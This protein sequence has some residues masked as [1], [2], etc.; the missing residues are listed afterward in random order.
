[1]YQH[2]LSFGPFDGCQLLLWLC[3]LVSTLSGFICLLNGRQHRLISCLCC[4]KC[5]WLLPQCTLKLWGIHCLSDRVNHIPFSLSYVPPLLFYQVS[6]LSMEW[7]NVMFGVFSSKSFD[8]S[9]LIY[10]FEHCVPVIT[11]T[12][13]TSS[14][15]ALDHRPSAAI[16]V[17]GWYVIR[18]TK[19]CISYFL[20]QSSL[21]ISG[22]CC[23]VMFWWRITTVVICPQG[24]SNG[25]SWRSIDL[26]DPHCTTSPD[27]ELLQS[28]QEVTEQSHQLR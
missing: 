7:K 3:T 24:F 2:L 9:S 6:P 17:E 19:I 20:M 12:F 10:P 23:A 22:V 13:L 8:P 14:V 26:P 11:D 15:P 16:L 18:C 27:I 1:M 21:G 28:E 25:S 4:H 5:R